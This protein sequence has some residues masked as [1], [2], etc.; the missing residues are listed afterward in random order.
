MAEGF[1]HNDGG[2]SGYFK[3][4]ADDCVCRAIAIATKLPYIDVYKG[5]GALMK[6]QKPR[7]DGKRPNTTPR[8][9]V[10]NK[11]TR[12]YMEQI[13]WE[14]VPTMKVGQGC[15]VHLKADELPKGRLVVKLSSHVTAMID[16][17][18]HDDHDPGRGGTRCVYG[19]W[20][21]PE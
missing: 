5:L 1:V 15:T 10:P 17:I 3:G 21:K 13:G 11:I 8:N 2:R 9:R 6:A 7:N 4:K 19:Y 18:I 12:K 20:R 16:G 14:W